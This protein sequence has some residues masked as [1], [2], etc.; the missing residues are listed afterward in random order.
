MNHEEL[1]IKSE[2]ENSKKPPGDATYGS[3]Q[4]DWRRRR[5]T[6]HGMYGIV[7]SRFSSSSGNSWWP[8][9]TYGD[10]HPVVF[11]WA[12]PFRIS[13]PLRRL[14]S[15]RRI[16]VLTNPEEAPSLLS[17]CFSSYSMEASLISWI[18][19]FVRGGP[20][21]HTRKPSLP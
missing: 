9:S 8:D 13:Q 19:A 7:H 11:S 15:S 2:G 10:F 3:S 5:S 14:R 1:G 12:S 20:G 21:V 17:A 4:D 16:G 18:W 6:L